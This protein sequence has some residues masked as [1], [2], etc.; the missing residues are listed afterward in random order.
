[1]FSNKLY[2][3][4][5]I[6]C[7][8]LLFTPLSQ[9]K[10]EVFSQVMDLSQVLEE[11]EKDTSPAKNILVIFD[12]DDTLL[13]SDTF[14]GSV[15]WYNWQRGRKVYSEQGQPIQIKQEQQFHCIF[16]TLG[17]L[18][19]MGTTKLTQANTAE[20][21]R[22]INQQDLLYL[23]ARTTIYR[24][25]TE[26]ELAKNGLS[27]EDKH[28]LDKGEI[29]HFN[30]ND[31][32]RTAK[33]TYEKGILMASG[34]NKGM[35]LKAILSKVNK[36]YD[37]IYFVDDSLKNVKQISNEW[38]ME[39]TLVKI[40]HYTKVDKKISQKEID[41]S[42]QSKKHFEEFIATAFPKRMKLLKQNICK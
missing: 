31:N 36:Q 24:S 17:T 20:I 2:T 6:L 1:M 11:L 14:V 12:I 40:F 3:F 19:E 22:Q 37:K 7:Y 16:S 38:K 13:E 5:L 30:F 35:V 41:T 15:K 32:Q 25:P 34:L 29:I 18:F 9:A 26:R 27:I 28:L 23:T 33:V 39:K 10:V 21:V 8:F 4:A 42:D